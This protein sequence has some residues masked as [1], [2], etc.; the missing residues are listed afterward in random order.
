MCLDGIDMPPLRQVNATVKKAP[1]ARGKRA[2]QR[3]L[4]L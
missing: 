3:K 4:D 2:A 1:K